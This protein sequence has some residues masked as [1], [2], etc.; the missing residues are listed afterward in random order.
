MHVRFSFSVI[1]QDNGWKERPRN[2]LFYVGWDVKTLTQSVNLQ[3]SICL[4][5]TVSWHFCYCM[6]SPVCN[7]MGDH[8]KQ[9]Y[10]VSM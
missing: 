1:S 10:H 7:G 4:L 9:A 3:F 5:S 6:S 8:L 2:G